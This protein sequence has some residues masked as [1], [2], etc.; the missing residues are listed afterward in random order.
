M[1]SEV[2]GAIADWLAVTLSAN[3]SGRT[4]VP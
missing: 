1:S 2:L 4:A 3:T